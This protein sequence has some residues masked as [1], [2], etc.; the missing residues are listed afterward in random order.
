[1]TITDPALRFWLRYLEAS[2]GLHEDADDQVLAMLPSQ[3]QAELGL[4]EELAVTTDPEVARENGALL[5]LPGHPVLDQAAASVLDRGD[6]GLAWLAWPAGTPPAPAALLE[7]ARERFDI[8][9]GRIDTGGHPARVYLPVLRVGAL[10]SYTAGAGERFQEREEVWVDGRTGRPLGQGILAAVTTAPRLTAPDSSHRALTPDLAVALARAHERMVERALARLDVLAR[11]AQAPLREE[12]AQTDAY[13]QAALQ[14]LAKRREQAE[15]DRQ[16]LLDARAE[17]TRVEHTRRRAE[18]Q[19]KFRPGHQVR[20][21]RLHLLLVP[22]VELPVQVRRGQTA[23]PFTLTW[24]LPRAGFVDPA[25]PHCGT[26]E[27]LVAGR[28]RL[29]CRAC[30]QPT[31]PATRPPAPAPPPSATEAPAPPTPPAAPPA[32]KAAPA[33]AKPARKPTRRPARTPAA[34]PAPT[35]DRELERA[36][37][38]A[39]KLPTAFWEAVAS[40]ERWPRKQVVPGSPLSVLYRLYGAEGPACAV[41]LAPGQSRR[42]ARISMIAPGSLLGRVAVITGGLALDDGSSYPYTLRWRLQAGKAAV[43]EV[44]PATGTAGPTLPQRDSLH[45]ALAR[46]LY[47]EVPGTPAQLDPVAAALWNQGS[48]HLGLPLVARSLAAW[49]RLSD[50]AALPNPPPV[51]AAGLAAL[52]GRFAGA[53]H[54]VQA[55]ATALDVDP[56]EATAAADDLQQ[57]LRLSP[58]QPW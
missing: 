6:A 16:R 45:P 1:M 54:P 44:L 53:W 10:V 12:L 32:P 36:W 31:K 34:S 35:P 7:R 4:P 5:L 58:Q 14:A 9:H 43:E 48:R 38:V 13:Y 28:D 41:G 37:R 47:D 27:R 2:G 57:R 51:L 20:P 39:N 15:P 23:H 40:G 46:R 50:P 3:L 55:V 30:L 49:W 19:E 21:F 22:A 11:R 56:A 17:A 25:C 29:G 52:T 26:A 42:L 8:D 18:I 33:A 24:V